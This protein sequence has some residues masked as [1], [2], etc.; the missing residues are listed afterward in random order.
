MS[1]Q[2]DY[3]IIGLHISTYRH[4]RNFTQEELA[5]CA[6]I[7]KQFLSNLERGKAIP[8][9]NTLMALCDALNITANDLLMHSA[10]HDPNAPSRL[11]D[12]CDAFE[13]TLTD[14]LLGHE[15]KAPAFISL[16]DLPLYD[17]ELDDITKDE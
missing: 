2:V 1:V 10:H 5:E 6:G 12:A 17:I 11:R 8:S 9:V 14:Q 13:N 15:A 4:Q 7:S 16:E 3:R